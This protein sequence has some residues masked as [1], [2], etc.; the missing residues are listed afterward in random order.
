MAESLGYKF[1]IGFDLA[2][3]FSLKNLDKKFSLLVFKRFIVIDKS[4]MPNRS[5]DLLFASIYFFKRDA[6]VDS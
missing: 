6:Y 4:F 1:L 2:I 5:L 3:G